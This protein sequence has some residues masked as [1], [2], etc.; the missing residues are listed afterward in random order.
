MSWNSPDTLLT[1]IFIHSLLAEL[2]ERNILLTFVKLNLPVSLVCRDDG[3]RGNREVH[4]AL[5]AAK[6]L[7]TRSQELSL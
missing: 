6:C 7:L 4:T 1:K 3:E 5:R 2:S